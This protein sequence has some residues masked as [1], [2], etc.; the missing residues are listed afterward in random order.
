M[1]TVNMISRLREP[2]YS[3][4]LPIATVSVKVKI[5]KAHC[6]RSPKCKG[7]MVTIE[8]GQPRLIVRHKNKM[9]EF[10]LLFSQ[11]NDNMEILLS[12]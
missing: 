7:I 2:G 9:I 1:E 5:W 11:D 10:D 4:N 3:K 6:I 12:T 8:V